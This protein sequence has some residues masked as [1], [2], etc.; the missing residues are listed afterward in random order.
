MVAIDPWSEAEKRLKQD[1]ALN[2]LWEESI[3]LAITSSLISRLH[4]IENHFL[5]CDSNLSADLTRTLENDLVLLCSKALDF[6]SR[7]IRYSQKRLA[8]QFLTDVFKKDAWDEVL[9]HV[10]RYDNSIR[11]TPSSIHDIR[12]DKKLQEIQNAL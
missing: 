5:S 1:V 4:I 7:A 9:R 10:G 2:K 8:V 11:N 12:V 6:Q 3:R